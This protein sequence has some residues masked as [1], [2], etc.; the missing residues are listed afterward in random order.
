MLFRS[1]ASLR[2]GLYDVVDG[3]VYP[4]ANVICGFGSPF[5]E[6][7][8]IRAEDNRATIGSASINPQPEFIDMITQHSKLFFNSVQLNHDISE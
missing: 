1:L 3:G 8:V 2:H 5:S 6:D 7:L 4:Y